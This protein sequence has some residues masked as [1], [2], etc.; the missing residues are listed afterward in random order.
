LAFSI[1]NFRLSAQRS[2][3]LSTD[4]EEDEVVGKG[5]WFPVEAGSPIATWDDR[6]VD[7]EKS[8]LLDPTVKSDVGL[9]DVDGNGRICAG[10]YCYGS[11]RARVD[12]STKI[13]GL[14]LPAITEARQRVMRDAEEAFDMLERSIQAAD[15]SHPLAED[16][17]VKKQLL[18]LKEITTSNRRFARAARSMLFLRGHP[19]LCAGPEDSPAH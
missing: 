5:D 8:V 3:R 18:R 10:R 1:E 7:K 16:L 9:I 17:A 15:K 6:C 4:E 2:N 12:A 14:N 13:Y 19:E 11:D